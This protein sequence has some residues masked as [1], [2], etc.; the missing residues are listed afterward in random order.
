MRN[1]FQ[2]IRNDKVKKLLDGLNNDKSVN[3][4]IQHASFKIQDSRGILLRKLTAYGLSPNTIN[5]MNSYLSGQL[6][7]LIGCSVCFLM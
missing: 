4:D 6:F 1:E 5:R 7:I 3:S 2:P